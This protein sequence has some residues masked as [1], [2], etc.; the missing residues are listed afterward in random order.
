M[1]L[2]DFSRT[3]EYFC[4]I[5]LVIILTLQRNDLYWYVVWWWIN[6]FNYFSSGSIELTSLLAIDAHVVESGVKVA[7]TLHSS[8]GLDLTVKVLDGYG[9]DVK[10]GLPVKKQEILNFNSDVVSIV[11]EMKGQETESPIKFDVQ[12]CVH[13]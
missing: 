13:N 3:K 8:T 12:R 1:S 4:N 9:V 11:R 2:H 5:I 7:A 10:I 6:S